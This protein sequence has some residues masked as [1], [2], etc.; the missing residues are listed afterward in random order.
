MTL[1][2]RN[3]HIT[4]FDVTTWSWAWVNLVNPGVLN[5]D[6]ILCQRELK[7]TVSRQ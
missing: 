7:S 4:V 3:V 5:E 1:C 6:I 2:V